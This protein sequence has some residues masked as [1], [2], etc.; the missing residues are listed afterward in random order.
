MM[1]PVMTKSMLTLLSKNIGRDVVI[2]VTIYVWYERI[3]LGSCLYACQSEPDSS[4]VIALDQIKLDTALLVT[5]NSIEEDP[6]VFAALIAIVSDLSFGSCSY[7]VSK[8]KHKG[9]EPARRYVW[10]IVVTTGT[11]IAHT[12]SRQYKQYRDRVHMDYSIH[13]AYR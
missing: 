13:R 9:F 6:V 5:V 7:R 2:T 11:G 10:L 8:M 3:K 4:F 1:K 12:Q